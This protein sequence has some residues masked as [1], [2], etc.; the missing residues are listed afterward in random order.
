MVTG[1]SARA[2][3]PGGR[4]TSRSW[5]RKEY[6]VLPSGE[7]AKAINSTVRAGPG[8]RNSRVILRT[9]PARQKDS[10]GGRAGVQPSATILTS[11]G[12]SPGGVDWPSAFDPQQRI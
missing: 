3:C 6:S 7:W 9:S 2:D 10:I 4:V 5:R 11:G 1:S 12:L 8:L